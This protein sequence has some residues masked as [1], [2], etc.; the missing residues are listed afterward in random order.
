MFYAAI[1]G[2]SGFQAA[3]NFRGWGTAMGRWIIRRTLPVL[4]L[5]AGVVILQGCANRS[6]TARSKPQPVHGPYISGGVGIG[7]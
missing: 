2:G 1:P 5:I 7:L 4:L 6:D 3:S